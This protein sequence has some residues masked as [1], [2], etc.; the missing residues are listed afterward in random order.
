MNYDLVDVLIL[1]SAEDYFVFT[2]FLVLFV[3]LNWTV[4]TIGLKIDV[5]LYRGGLVVP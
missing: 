2:A 1:I 3:Y 4:S 5:L